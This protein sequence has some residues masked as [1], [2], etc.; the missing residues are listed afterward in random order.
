M[1][2][3]RRRA[4]IGSWVLAKMTNLAMYGTQIISRYTCV[5]KLTDS[6]AC[7]QSI[8]QNLNNESER[9]H[10]KLFGHPLNVTTIVTLIAIDRITQN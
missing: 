2:K 8:S 3:Q 6:W 10:D 9:N 5:A 1:Q 7:R 4:S